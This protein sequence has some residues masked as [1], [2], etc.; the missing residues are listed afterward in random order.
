MAHPFVP[1]ADLLVDPAPPVEW[2]IPEFI[3]QGSLIALAGEPGAGKSFLI[4]T[5]ALALATGTSTLGWE[6]E[7]KRVLYF[8]QENSRSDFLQYFKWAW[9]G[10]GRP[11][12]TLI[13]ENLGFV[14]FHLGGPDW[15]SRAEAAI[16]AFKP[17]LIVFD[18][19]TPSFAIQDENSNAE[20]T[21]VITK[22]RRLQALTTPTATIIALKHV[23][24]RPED[25][26]FT[27]RGAKAWEGA[28]DSVIYQLKVPGRP[29]KGGEGLRRTKLEPSKT[30]AFGLRETVRIAPQWIMEGSERVGLSLTRNGTPQD[31]EDDT[32]QET[33]KSRK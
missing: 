24:R 8:D 1:I 5:L 20:A 30:R 26:D 14:S 11:D 32:P 4:Y 17:Q 9:I 7:P 33:R 23:R 16:H 27:L 2:L 3:P 12:R 10:L 22:L 6:I 21:L 28:V 13:D 15:S 25:G 29:P 31:D 18:T 19:T